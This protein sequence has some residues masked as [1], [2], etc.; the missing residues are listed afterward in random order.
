MVGVLIV[1]S[2]SVAHN[3]THRSGS[4][5]APLLSVLEKVQEKCEREGSEAVPAEVIHRD[6]MTI[7]P[8]P[9]SGEGAR[10]T[11]KR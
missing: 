1:R 3:N 5:A 2:S 7:L 8:S 6:N 11:V 9:R 4:L 10:E